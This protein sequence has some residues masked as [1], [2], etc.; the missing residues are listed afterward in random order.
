MKLMDQDARKN[1]DRRNHAR[2][3][4]EITLT[5]RIGV[6]RASVTA[7]DISSTGARIVMPA[8]FSKAKEIVLSGEILRTT[9]SIRAQIVWVRPQADGMV[10]AGVRFL[11]KPSRLQSSWA[12]SHM[13][14]RTNA[15]PVECDIEVS[16]RAPG[17]TGPESA[18]LRLLEADGATLEC[19]RHLHMDAKFTL[20]LPYEEGEK[21]LQLA[22][23]VVHRQKSGANWLLSSQFSLSEKA[24]E[25]QILHHILTQA[26]KKNDP[27]VKKNEMVRKAVE[28]A[29]YVVEQP[30]AAGEPPDMV[31]PG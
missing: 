10:L 2:R 23:Q 15:A 26:A 12:A 28:Q 20:F 18:R 8:Q 24:R 16:L 6:E 21:V 31:D 9:N 19:V 7:S 14:A 27:L 29:P 13:G 17:W 3:N 11:E 4:C 5:S 1:L 25:R 22:C 30:V